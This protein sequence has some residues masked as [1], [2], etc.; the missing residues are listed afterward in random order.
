MAEEEIQ[1][2]NPTNFLT[3]ILVEGEKAIEEGKLAHFFSD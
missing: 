3:K 2:K 1:G